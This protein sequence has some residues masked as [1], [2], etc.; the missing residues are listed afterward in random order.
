MYKLFLCLRYLKSR[1]LAYFAMLGVMLCVAM[2]LIVVSVM[3][4]FLDKIESAAKGLFGDVIIEAAGQQGL[5]NYDELIAAIRKDVGEVE[6]AS[7]FIL[8]YGMIRIP[9]TDY[10]RAVQIA[11][12]RLPERVHVSSFGQGLFVQDG[13]GEPTFHPPI[14]EMIRWA[15]SAHDFTYGLYDAKRKEATAMAVAKTAQKADVADRLAEIQDALDRLETALQRQLQALETLERARQALPRMQELRGTLARLKAQGKGEDDPAHVAAAEELDELVA[16]TKFHAP[17]KRIILGLGIQGLIYRTPQGQTVRMMLPGHEVLLYVFPLGRQLT[18]TELEPNRAML[19][20]VDDS[21]TD[22]SSIDAEFVYVPFETVQQ[23]NNMHADGDLPARCSQIHV[24][25]RGLPTER[26]LQR[27]A[28]RIRG[29]WSTFRRAYP[30]A[31]TT[32]VSVQTWRQRQV[33]VISPIE[34]QRT[35]VVVMFAIIS[36]VAVVL[37]FVIF[38]TIVVQ[39]TRDIGVL[40]A[41]GASSGGVGSI[42]LL[43]GG[44][45][46]LVGAVLGTV[47]GVVFVRNINPIHDWV[48]RH[49]GLQVWSREWFLFEKIPNEVDPLNAVLIVI[50]TILAGVIGALLPAVRAARLQPVEALRYE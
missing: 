15:R 20:V 33:R 48:G 29:V 32:E 5:G 21:R 28:D 46:G 4:G 10:R 43:Y 9:N 3:N 1:I 16:R 2:M 17:D 19:T 36:T 7:P 44:A 23:L 30:L 6:A 41:V 25:V 47:L 34:S 8:S 42:F 26:D 39:K 45:V 31:A 38:Y 35:L 24:K 50:A 11:G 12:I 37:I 22:V 40:K 18:T 13:Q 14:D 49:L 27:V